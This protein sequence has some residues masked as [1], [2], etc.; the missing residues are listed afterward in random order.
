M[1]CLFSRFK[2][3]EKVILKWGCIC[4][5]NLLHHWCGTTW[6]G[7]IKW[8]SV[9]LIIWSCIYLLQLID[10]HPILVK[11]VVPVLEAVILTNVSAAVD[12][13][14]ITVKVS[15]QELLRSWNICDFNQADQV[16]CSEHLIGWFVVVPLDTVYAKI[17]R[18]LHQHWI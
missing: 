15:M 7:S 6:K 16:W 2:Y 13:L 18:K 14:E 8:Y 1:M 3:W 11:M 17:Y 10:V 9:I 5:H 4:N 12:S